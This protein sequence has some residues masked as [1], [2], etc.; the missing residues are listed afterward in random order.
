MSR[1]GWSA[2]TQQLLKDESC[3]VCL[4]SVRAVITG[5]VGLNGGW[6]INPGGGGR[7]FEL[8]RWQAG[9][10]RKQSLC[11]WV[12]AQQL[13]DQHHYSQPEFRAHTHVLVLKVPT[14]FLLL[15]H[16][17]HLIHLVLGLSATSTRTHR[18]LFLS[19]FSSQLTFYNVVG[20][21]FSEE[22]NL[23]LCSCGSFFLMIACCNLLLPNWFRECVHTAHELNPGSV[24]SGST[25]Y[26]QP[27]VSGWFHT[28]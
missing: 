11:C 19:L 20:P 3:I 6:L 16:G 7:W 9:L 10:R 26:F 5:V 2:M 14:G 4:N 1:C 8:L 28:F 17:I 18:C 23:L 13:L 24:W 12:W 22:L 21:Y 25:N 27:F 15:P